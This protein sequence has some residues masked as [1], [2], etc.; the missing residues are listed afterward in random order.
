[1]AKRKVQ[2]SAKRATATTAK[3]AVPKA[4][5]SRRHAAKPETQ[6]IE[7]ALAAFAHDVRTPLTG[8]LALSELLATSELGERE[9]RWVTALKDTAEHLTALTTLVVDAARAEVEG[10]VLRHDAFDLGAFVAA[11]AESMVVR[12][13]AKG[14]DPVA[15]IAAGLPTAVVGD[16]VRL[17]GAVENL[18]DNAVKFTEQGAVS[19]QVTAVPARGGRVRVTFAV[20]DSGIGMTAA[21]IRRLFRPFA[22]ANADVAR[23]YGGAG[24]GLVLVKRL[25]EAMAGRLTVKSRPGRGSTFM[26]SVVLARAATTDAG[27][28]D[29]A[30]AAVQPAKACRVLCAEDNPYGRVILATILKELGHGV[31]FVG[32]G[33]AAVSAATGGGYDLILMDVTLP[34]GDGIEATRRIRALPG[35]AARVPIIGVSGLSSPDEEARARAAGMNDYLA[36]PV[37]PARLARAI[38]GVG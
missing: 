25:A 29:A 28:G 30:T 14:L 24:L 18:I 26:L 38:A 7:K 20:S 27:H 3:R 16:P 23:R 31:D 35:E 2:R 33:N 37:S 15:D 34:N 13:A 5:A 1:M 21:E 19:L 9:R 22:Q 10:I 8:I 4:R 36:K 12:A 17:R 6:R 32:S 11:F